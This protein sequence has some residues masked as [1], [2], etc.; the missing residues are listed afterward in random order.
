MAISFADRYGPWALVTGAS[1]GLGAAFAHKCAERGLNTFLI[2]RS[3]DLLREQARRIEAAY[4]VSTKTL[5][6]DLSRQDILETI[7]PLTDTLEVGLVINNA[8]MSRVRPF[9]DHTLEQLLTQL[10][11]NARAALILAYHFGGKM[12]ERGRGGIIFVSSAS[13]MNGTAFVANYAATKA[14]NLI[15]G[16]S[17]WVEL[18]AKGVDVLGF[19]PGSTKS[20]GWY[21]NEPR[22]SPWVKVMEAED[23]VTEALDAIGR[24]PSRIAGRV[25]RWA[26]FFMGRLLSRKRAIRTVSHTMVD[27]FGQ[28]LS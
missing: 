16:E 12:V 28:D 17:L 3:E 14:Y 26:Y 22:D 1:K 10:H 13:A 9:L 27:L 21:E 6:L 8:G 23:A 4:G 5:A 19:M 25:N 24:A 18:R 20:P 2:A 7:S 11:L 15:M